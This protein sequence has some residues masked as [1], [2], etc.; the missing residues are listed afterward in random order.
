MFWPGAAESDFFSVECEGEFLVHLEVNTAIIYAPMIC[1]ET[2]II[3][4]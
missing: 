3:S 2:K 1:V 4:K